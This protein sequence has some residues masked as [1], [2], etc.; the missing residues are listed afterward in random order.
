MKRMRSRDLVRPGLF[1]VPA[2][3]GGLQ[4]SRDSYDPLST[5][6]RPELAIKK[7]GAGNAYDRQGEVVQ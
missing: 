1:F 6:D 4:W 5:R 2:Q 3:R 7:P